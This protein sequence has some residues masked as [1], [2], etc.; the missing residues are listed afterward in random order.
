MNR[1]IFIWG[2]ILFAIL[3]ILV[4]TGASLFASSHG[5]QL[6]EG[7][8]SPCVVGGVDY[9]DTL[10]GLGLFFFYM[11]ITIPVGGVIAAIGFL[12]KDKSALVG[13]T[14]PSSKPSKKL[15]WTGLLLI[16]IPP[17]VYNILVLFILRGGMDV[18]I[19]SILASIAGPLAGFA[20]MFCVPLGVVVLIVGIVRYFKSKN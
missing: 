9:A 14:V 16:F 17:V 7:S 12:K 4:S 1:K 2:G 15:I 8:P 10:Y 5:C 20:T 6:N 18:P 19:I 11:F 3:P 13:N